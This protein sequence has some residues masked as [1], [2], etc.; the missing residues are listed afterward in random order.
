[1]DAP[2]P[3]LFECYADAIAGLPERDRLFK[4]DLLVE[5]FRVFKG[6]SVEIYYAPF[7]FVN[8]EA[9]IAIVGITPGW[10]QME[11]GFRRARAVLRDGGTSVEGLTKGKRRSQFRRGDEEQSREDAR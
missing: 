11:I 10:T 2:F 6:E 4:T 9:K 7:D 5:Q 3:Q 8:V 1:V